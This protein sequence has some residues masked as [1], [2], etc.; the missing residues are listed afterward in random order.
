MRDMKLTIKVFVLLLL[1]LL[2]VSA[3]ANAE[4]LT[5]PQG[6]EVILVFDQALSSK[7]AKVGESVALHVK[8]DVKIADA[9]VLAAGTKVTA[10]I[11][12]VDKRK[13]Y[14][15]NAKMRIVLNPVASA[16]GGTLALEPR[17]K[18]QSLGGTKTNQAAGATAGGA[19]L[20]GPVGLI[21]GYFVSGKSV[22][23]KVGDE[24]STQVS[25]TVT[26]VRGK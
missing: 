8:N 15:I 10:T 23:I 7:T 21:G 20:L 25:T 14:G 2:A 11:S 19:I 22:T 5:V 16:F 3:V 26:L 1:G 18:G 12:Q 24:L 6:T 13:R 17:S 4:Q 9:T